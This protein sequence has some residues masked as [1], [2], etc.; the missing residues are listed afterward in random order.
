MGEALSPFSMLPD[1]M[2]SHV[3]D[4]LGE[5]TAGGKTNVSEVL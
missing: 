1:E 2:C 5:D 3:L 4:F